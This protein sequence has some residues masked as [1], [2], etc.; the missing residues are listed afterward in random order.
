MRAPFPTPQDGYDRT[1]ESAFRKL[2]EQEMASLRTALGGL[3]ISQ[4]FFNVQDYAPTGTTTW[5]DAFS[6]ADTDAQAANGVILVPPGTYEIADNIT[7]TAP[8]L[9]AGGKIKTAS[10]KT[11]T[12]TGPITA[13]AGV[14]EDNSLGGTVAVTDVAYQNN[15]MTIQDALNVLGDIYGGQNLLLTG[16]A[17]IGDYLQITNQFGCNGATAQSAYASGGAVSNTAATN[18]APYGYTT[19]AQADGIVTLLN[20]IQAALVANGIM[21]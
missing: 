17:M 2:V 20:N 1:N 8:I 15:P 4:A 21:S 18:V 13:L 14:W 9:F 11:F 5:D 12:A 16:Y 3:T 7:I 6:G 10:G 19:Q